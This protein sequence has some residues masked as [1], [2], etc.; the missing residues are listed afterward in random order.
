[1]RA[2][3]VPRRVGYPLITHQLPTRNVLGSGGFKSLVPRRCHPNDG[4]TNLILG[5]TVVLY[6]TKACKGLITVDKV[7]RGETWK[8]LI[9]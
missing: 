1:M 4:P 8:S 6:R 2:P 7:W 9:L 5:R 3:L